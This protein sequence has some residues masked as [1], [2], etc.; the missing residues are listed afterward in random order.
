MTTFTL[1]G[2]AVSP[3]ATPG[4]KPLLW[5]LREEL[6][7]TYLFISHDLGV[8]RHLADRVAIMYLGR[9][10]EQGPVD[11]V[12][13]RP[14]HPYAAALR[15][16][17]LPPDASA[18]SRLNRIDGE[19]PSALDPPSGCHF[20][21]RCP[22]VKPICRRCPPAWTLRETARGVACYLYAEAAQSAPL[23]RP[24]GMTHVS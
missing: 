4:D 2:K 24:K 14:L 15:D 22:E 18:R 21:P 9:I 3:T 7:L 19:M 23:F 1:N 10:V 6:G 16:S 13:E 5:V 8:V 20:H 11:Q 17:T 12:F